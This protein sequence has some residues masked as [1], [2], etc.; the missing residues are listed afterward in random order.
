MCRKRFM[1]KKATAWND[2]SGGS[3]RIIS[4]RG[5]VGLITRDQMSTR[6]PLQSAQC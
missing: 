6:T 4:K 5:V 1:R 3:I 2:D